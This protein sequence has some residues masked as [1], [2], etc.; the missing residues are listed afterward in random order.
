MGC[1]H[2]KEDE[3]GCKPQ[4]EDKSYYVMSPYVHSNTNIWSNCSKTFIT[5]LF[6]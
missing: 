4:A 2:D 1:G 6:E 3:S 5:E